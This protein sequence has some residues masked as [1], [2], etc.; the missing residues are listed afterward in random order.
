ML[1]SFSERTPPCGTPV[2]SCFRDE[3]GFLNCDDICVCVVNKQ[4]QLLEFV[5][6]SV[7]VNLQ[8]E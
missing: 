2:L 7:Y 8:Y 5:F 3:F 4:F 6:D 1:N